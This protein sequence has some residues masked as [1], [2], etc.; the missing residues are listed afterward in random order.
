MTDERVEAPDRAESDEAVSRALTRALR[1]TRGVVDV[2]DA[3]PVVEAAVT[4]VAEGLDLAEPTGLVDVDRSDGLV[5][6]TAHVATDVALPTPQTLARAADVVRRRVAD[7][8]AGA[9]E[10]VVSVT[11]RLVEAPREAAPPAE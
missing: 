7:L 8:G 5:V 11:A 6:V 9:D 4:L 3:H 10:V 1:D 2:F